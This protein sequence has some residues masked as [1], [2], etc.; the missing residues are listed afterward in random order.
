MSARLL[1]A[2]ALVACETPAPPA[3]LDSAAPVEPGDGGPSAGAIAAAQ[4]KDDA[5]SVS[6]LHDAHDHRPDRFDGKE[7]RVRG[8][9][10]ASFEVTV[11]GKPEVIMAVVGAVDTPH[12]SVSCALPREPDDLE[13]GDAVVV[14]GTVASVNGVL[15]LGCS[16][17][18]DAAP[19]EP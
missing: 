18:K 7:V 3:A 17:Q 9:Y 15:L 6:G 10:F 16:Y 1:L 12:P 19:P 2:C 8:R 13:P 14:S 5:L 4:P 11:A